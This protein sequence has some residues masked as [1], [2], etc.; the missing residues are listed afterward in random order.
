MWLAEQAP[1]MV[2]MSTVLL[3]LFILDWT[4]GFGYGAQEEMAEI[5]SL[6]RRRARSLWVLLGMVL[7]VLNA[8]WLYY[9]PIRTQYFRHPFQSLFPLAA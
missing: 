5:W 2:N 1:I 3:A 8:Q 4:V 6:L 7:L 9:V